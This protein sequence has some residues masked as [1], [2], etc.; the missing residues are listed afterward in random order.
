STLPDT[1]IEPETPCPAVTIATTRPTTQSILIGW[2]FVRKAFTQQVHIKADND[3]ELD[4]FD[5]ITFYM[6][7]DCTVSAMV[8]AQRVTDS[9]LARSNTLSD[10]KIVVSNL[11]S[12]LPLRNFRKTEKSPV[13]LR[14][15]R[16]SNP[17]PLARQSHLQPLGQRG[18]RLNIIFQNY[19]FNRSQK[20]EDC[21]G[22]GDW[23]D[24]GGI[25]TGV[26][27]HT[28][29]HNTILL[30]FLASHCHAFY[31]RRGRQKVKPLFNVHPLFTI[32]GISPI[33]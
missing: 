13:I 32:C 11:D 18:S 20:F 9:I 28:M 24:W 30:L 7:I 4:V 23:E 26:I 6:D 22:I 21:W 17:R 10:L 1:E 15:T 14:P 2:L 31:P 27:T 5:G 29:N 12:V 16:E 3:D 33:I 19:N 8:A 25:T